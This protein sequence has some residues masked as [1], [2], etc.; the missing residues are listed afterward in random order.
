MARAGQSV[1]SNGRMFVADTILQQESSLSS[2]VHK[3]YRF[4]YFMLQDFWQIM[5]I[6]A[7]FPLFH[8]YLYGS[9]RY[10]SEFKGL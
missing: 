4:L 9:H 10:D 7:A 8:K 5:D 6:S 3:S 2:T 1:C